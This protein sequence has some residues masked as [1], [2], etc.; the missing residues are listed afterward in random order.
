M[1]TPLIPRKHRRLMS[2][3]NSLLTALT[4]P[5]NESEVLANSI[6]DAAAGLGGS[7]AAL[8]LVP[9]PAARALNVL[10]SRGLTNQQVQGLVRGDDVDAIHTGL[11]RTAIAS[12][13]MQLEEVAET[14]GT[15]W[16]GPRCIVCAP[17]LDAGTGTVTA[18]LY[19]QQRGTA[20]SISADGD[21][22]WIEG[23]AAAM[24]R[25]FGHHFQRLRSE[26]ALAAITRRPR[27][28]H[29]PELIGDSA[30]THAL[31]RD[32]HETYIPAV[33]AVDPEP[34]LVLGER[35]TGKDLIARYLHAYS[36]RRQRPFVAVNCAEITDELAA[37]RF[38]GHKRGSF[39][40]AV[41]D[42]L[43][44]FRA[45]HSG[46]LFLDEIAEL[47]LR[48]QSTLLRVLENRTVVPVGETREVAV[49][50]QVV[51]AT[52]RDLDQA[53][54]SG[55]I[56]RDLVD[57]FRTQ[58]IRMD[59]LRD[60]PADIASL[61]RHFVAH[62][63][64]RMSK[65][66]LGIDNEALRMMVAYPWPGNVREVARVCALLVT[67]LKPGAP[68]DRALLLRCY[69]QMVN[70]TMNPKSSPVLFEDLTL[71]DALRMMQREV[72]LAR[73]QR[74]NWNVRTTR[75]SLGLPKTTFHRYAMMLGIA[76]HEQRALSRGMLT[77]A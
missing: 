40:G 54:T 77:S 5:G 70:H 37:S 49:N 36:A 15:P 59:P 19:L 61:V 32:L 9:D 74:H 52:N 42:E 73:L 55:E 14:S 68:L 39:T 60:R 16:T 3:I 17:I 75:E 26:Q 63:L 56:R 8:L 20:T 21:I 31:R 48:A 11:I 6:E 58:A 50:V 38:F 10:H 45:A 13:A 18:V 66:T 41:A 27:P 62:H 25:L 72:V 7:I 47:S 64:Q 69:P 4:T 2:A 44:L 46:V 76:V 71:R 12:A 28:P 43:G 23:Y 33:D 29:A 1:T 65:P 34:V 35:G 24:S 22:E 51:L 67:H 53:M 57:R 30:Q